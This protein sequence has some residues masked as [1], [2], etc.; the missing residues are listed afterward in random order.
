MKNPENVQYA[1][2]R[3]RPSVWRQG[4]KAAVAM[5]ILQAIIYLFNGTQE[6]SF[7]IFVTLPLVFFVYWFFFTFLVWIWRAIKTPS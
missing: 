3:R 7:D 5:V 4:A 1:L 2:V 6:D